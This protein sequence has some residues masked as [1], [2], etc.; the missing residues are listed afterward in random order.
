MQGNCI[1]TSW[2]NLLCKNEFLLFYSVTWVEITGT[3][4]SHGSVVVLG[5][6]LLPKFGIIEDIFVDNFHSYFFVLEELQTVCFSP[7]YHS[8]E[9]IAHSPKMYHVCKPSDLFDHNVLGKY[10]VSSC[11]S[12]FVPLKYYLTEIV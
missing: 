5:T 6:D 9:V 4:Y 3:H 2:S 12:F 8:Y 1:Y 7:Q 11:H 10:Q